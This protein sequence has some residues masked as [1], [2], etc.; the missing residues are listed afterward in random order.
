MHRLLAA[1]CS[2]CGLS[3]LPQVKKATEIST[4]EWNEW[5]KVEKGDK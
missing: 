5:V 2:A 1:G 3:C 4:L